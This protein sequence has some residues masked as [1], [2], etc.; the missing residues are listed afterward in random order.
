MAHSLKVLDK[1]NS[2]IML[3]KSY[4]LFVAFVHVRGLTECSMGLLK[5]EAPECSMG[6]PRMW[7]GL[8]VGGGLLSGRPPEWEASPEWGEASPSVGLPECGEASHF[9]PPRMW[10]G[11]PVGGR[12]PEV[13]GLL[14]GR[15]PE[16]EASP[17]CRWGITKKPALAGF[18]LFIEF[19][20]PKHAHSCYFFDSRLVAIIILHVVDCRKFR[21][22]RAKRENVVCY[23]YYGYVF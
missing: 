15:P 14:S 20:H 23:S 19:S 22:I 10:R 13:R 3:Q 21:L 12:P 5:W 7:R 8:P 2:Y 4:L 1:A 6:P 18:L 17:E 9:R 11:L 16:W